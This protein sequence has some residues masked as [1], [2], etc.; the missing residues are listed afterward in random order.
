M[1]RALR[2]PVF[3]GA[4]RTIEYEIVPRIQSPVNLASDLVPGSPNVSEDV[5]VLRCIDCRGAKVTVVGNAEL[6]QA[7]LKSGA[8]SNPTGVMLPREESHS[9]SKDGPSQAERP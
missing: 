3:P 4:V 8:A 2:L 5:A 7:L 6:F 1:R 9:L